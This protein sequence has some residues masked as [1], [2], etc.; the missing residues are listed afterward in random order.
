MKFLFYK[1]DCRGRPGR[2]VVKFLHSASMA[3][4]FPVRIQGA[5]LQ[6]AYQAMPWQVSHI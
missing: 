3:W 2:V 4:C 6:T 5:D 1:T